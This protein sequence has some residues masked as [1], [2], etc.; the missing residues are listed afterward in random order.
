METEASNKQTHKQFCSCL[1]SIYIFIKK[2]A[3]KSRFI[4]VL[5]VLLSTVG[6]QNLTF[7]I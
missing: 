1:Y 2:S 4:G 7:M 3:K 6:G 5:I